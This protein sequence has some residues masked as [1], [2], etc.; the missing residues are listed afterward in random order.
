MVLSDCR[1][2]HHASPF[3]LRSFELRRTSR[4]TRGTATPV[5]KLLQNA[6][7]VEASFQ[8]ECRNRSYDIAPGKSVILTLALTPKHPGKPWSQRAHSPNSSQTLH[9]LN[10]CTA[11]W[12][13]SIHRLPYRLGGR[14]PWR[15][16]AKGLIAPQGGRPLRESS[17]LQNDWKSRSRQPRAG[18]SNSRESFYLTASACSQSGSETRP[19]MNAG[20]CAFE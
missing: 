2:G 18:L 16:P 9:R 20:N 4:A 8:P 5:A 12:A 17:R 7:K 11:A 14:P 10:R 6:W 3:R 1:P 15:H 19:T 13:T